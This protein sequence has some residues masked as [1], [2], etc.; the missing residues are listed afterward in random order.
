MLRK[1]RRKER[2]KQI[3][4]GKKTM[5]NNIVVDPKSCKSDLKIS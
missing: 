5:M 3:W 2:A 4:A 1:L